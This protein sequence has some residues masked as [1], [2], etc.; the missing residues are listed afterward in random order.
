MKNYKDFSFEERKNY[1]ERFV[2]NNSALIQEITG[3]SLVYNISQTPL[4]LR[5]GVDAIIQLDRGLSGVALR[6]RKPQY[7][8][9]SKRFTIGHHIS[10]PNSQIH[11]ILNST[12][13]SLVFYPHFILQ[14]NGVNDEG[15]C[16]DCSAILLQTDVFAKYLMNLINTN[17]L[18]DYYMPVL[19]AY[20]FLYSN[21]FTQ[22]DTGV[23]LF[24]I[25]N[26]QIKYV[27]TH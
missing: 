17:Q 13:K 14:V 3:A 23:D 6:I 8:R 11:T 21:V 19:D 26:N 20:E 10:K 18:E 1:E 15:Y 22:T 16:K 12:N 2:Q 27:H 7:K 25:E 9:F 5:S 4:D 24:E